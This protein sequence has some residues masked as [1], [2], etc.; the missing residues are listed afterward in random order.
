[1][2]DMKKQHNQNHKQKQLLNEESK[3]KERHIVTWTQE[4]FQTLSYNINY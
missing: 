2:Q 3:K 4:V 1:M